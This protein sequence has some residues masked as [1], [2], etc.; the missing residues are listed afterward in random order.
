MAK[1]IDTNQTK[2]VYALRKSGC[3]VYVTSM[4]G[5]GF[6]DIVVGFDGINYL[7]EIKNP[8]NPPSKRKL[9]EDEEKFFHTWAG[10]VFCVT[11]CDEIMEIIR[12]NTDHP[13]EDD[14][15]GCAK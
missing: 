6:P 11:S 7:F 9:T 14:G 3:S 8:D 15:K 4:V 10:A 13:K 12:P 5:H 1:R 2:I